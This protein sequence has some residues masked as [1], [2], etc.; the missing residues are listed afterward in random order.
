MRIWLCRSNFSVNS[1]LFVCSLYRSWPW[2]VCQN[3]I[4][5]G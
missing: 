1:C 4:P 3:L 2:V 5:K